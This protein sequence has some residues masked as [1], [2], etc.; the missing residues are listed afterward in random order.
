MEEFLKVTEQMSLFETALF[1]LDNNQICPQKK[2][3]TS[4]ELVELLSK[5]YKKKKM[6][7]YLWKMD[8]GIRSQETIIQRADRFLEKG[9]SFQGKS[10]ALI[11]PFDWKMADNVSRN[12]KFKIQS[13]Y[14]L[15]DI[16]EAYSLTSSSAYLESSRNICIDWIDKFIFDNHQN[17]YAWYDMGTGLRATL[18]AYVTVSSILEFR[19]NKTKKNRL[20]QIKILNLN[21]Y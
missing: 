13:W 12:H 1:C 5:Y 4:P 11:V 15:Y 3:K 6:S 9:F 16:M 8:S 17:E 10:Y 14:H 18:L 19:S 21:R 7:P 20:L 2:P